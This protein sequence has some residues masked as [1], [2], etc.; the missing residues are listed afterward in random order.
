[1]TNNIRHKEIRDR[2][3]KPSDPVYAGLLHIFAASGFNVTLAAAAIVVLTRAA[4]APLVVG[5]LC[6]LG[7]IGFYYWLVGPSPSVTRATIMAVIL[8]AAILVGRRADPLASTAAAALIMLTIDPWS[9]FDI[10]FQLSFASL[11][12]LL[13]LAPMINDW[14][15]PG[16][17]DKVA[18]ITY[19]AGAQ[20]AVTPFLLYHFGQFSAV[21]I[22]A[23]PVVTGAVAVVTVGGFAGTLTGLVW[24]AFGSVLIRLLTV[25]IDFI[26]GSTAFFSEIPGA[27]VQVGPS[28][29]SAG[30][31]LAVIILGL[32]FIKTKVKL[33]TL[34]VIIILVIALQTAGIWLEIAGGVQTA[35][36]VADFLDIGQGDATVIRSR[37]GGVILIDGG[38]RFRALDTSLR[39]RGIRQIDLLI[40]SHGH[41]DHVGALARLVDEYPIDLII[42]PAF[43]NPTDTYRDFKKSVRAHGVSTLTAVAGQRVMVEDMRVDILWPPELTMIGTESDVN[44]NSVVASVKYKDF[45]LLM[46]G[47]IQLEAIS[48]LSRR[49]ADLRASVLKVSHQGAANGTTDGFLRSVDPIYAVISVG[50]ENNYGHPHKATLGK[51][52]RRVRDIARTDRDG[53][54]RIETDGREVRLIK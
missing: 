38:E 22:V 42:E 29:L 33:I 8:Y 24:P 28:A 11:L 7:G 53:D 43:K 32:R 37:A 47:D 48:A 1:M 9:L 3:G 54:V 31:S 12:G 10:G 27:T 5:G 16:I 14:V 46:P 25:P 52:R 15:E 21:A 4:R 26:S 19:T 44:N 41:A 50:K 40:V 20:L 18:P 34:P 45:R 30:L 6:G 49:R 36:V 35:E 13:V 39:R 23:N 51:L 17:A 2:Q